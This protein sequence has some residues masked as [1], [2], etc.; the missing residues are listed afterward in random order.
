MSKKVL[1]TG[2]SYSAAP[3]LFSLRQ[4]GDYDVAV[5]GSLPNDPCH[6]YA[7]HSYLTDYSQ[8][9]LLVDLVQKEKIDY[10]CPSCNDYSYLSCAWVA[11]QCGLPGYDP[12]E[13]SIIIHNKKEFRKFAERH[14]IPIPKA[15]QA[16]LARKTDLAH[17]KF[18]LLAKPV[19]SFSGRG[20]NKIFSNDQLDAAIKLAIEN[21]LAQEAVLEEFVSGTLHSH[22]AFINKGKI[23]YDI[24]IDE[25]CTVYP[26]QVNCSNSPTSLSE[27]IQ[28][29]VREC[30]A[31][32]VA[33]LDLNDGLLHTQFI[34]NG[35]DFWLIECMRRCPGDLYYKMV[36]LST[37]VDGIDLFIRPFLK[38]RL[39]QSINCSSM[40]YWAR[41]TISIS[42]PLVVF[43]FAHTIPAQ[44]V[45][46]VP[47]KNS[48]EVLDKAP[49]DKLAIIFARF[50]NFQELVK[51]T[52]R[53]SEYI[54]IQIGG[55]I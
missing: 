55:V 31:E 29:K 46:I 11:E 42:E 17:L 24:F 10:L 23:G 30:I 32:I 48:G 41:H 16:S 38:E 47:L 4:R 28:L 2:T 25:F 9:E 15:T 7:D 34:T 37:G 50:P 18:P 8:R 27:A 14:G 26:Y 1:L 44:E 6:I 5:C 19:D 53:L 20:I 51:H 13:T 54:T 49:Y 39:P 33:I 52:Q 35:K 45:Q 21:S 22:S 3:I 12:Y 40:N 36:E 43:S